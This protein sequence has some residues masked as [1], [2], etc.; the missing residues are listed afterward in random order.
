MSQ[1]Y[2]DSGAGVFNLDGEYIVDSKTSTEITL[3]AAGVE[4]PNWANFD[5]V[6]AIILDTD[7]GVSLN[8]NIAN[9]SEQIVVGP[10]TVPGEN[11][12]EV[13][14]DVVAPKGLAGGSNLDK[15]LSV[16]V[17]FTFEEIDDLG[18]PTGPSFTYD[19]TV[20]DDTTDARFYT[21]KVDSSDGIVTGNRYRVSAQRF[22]DSNSKRDADQIK[23]QRLASVKFI[24]RVDQPRTTRV[25]IL[26]QA[27]EQVASIQERKFNCRA[28]RKVL[29]W[30]GSQVVGDINSGVGL[31]ASRRFADVFLHYALDPDLGARQ[32]SNIDVETLYS[33][34]NQ[35]DSVFNGE[36]GEFSFTFDNQNTPA[37]EEMRQIVDA[38]RCFMT[39]TGSYLSFVRD[40]SQ[41]I[42][43]GLFNRRNKRPDSE[44]K[45]I[46]FNRPVDNDGVVF[47]FFNRETN[48]SQTISL[49]QDLPV[50]DPN[51]GLPAPVNPKK[52]ESAGIKN[53]SQAWD[54][55]QYEFNR[56]IHSRVSVETTVSADAAT[57]P[58]NA[59]VSHVDGTKIVSASSDGEIKAYSG[60]EVET[61]EPCIFE[62]GKSY[63][64][65][66]RDEDGQPSSALPVTQRG[67]SKNGFVLV[68]A[69]PLSLYIRGENDYQRGMLYNF[70]ED[71][72]EAGELYLL[73]RKEPEG[74]FYY[75]L[76]LIN[77]TEKYYQADN[78]TPPEL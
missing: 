44:N 8:P 12:S 34:Q 58:L 28:V 20:T 26:T 73:Q 57:L 25:K 9:V 51:Y 23:W 45:S 55:A 38:A 21:F 31:S 27:T 65:I 15:N 56:V 19:R 14:L 62:P 16:T 18:A 36:K 53:Y 6:T 46:R 75:K 68:S 50:G 41:P 2:A 3:S 48:Q 74:D 59:R 30:D 39:R 37:L 35:L 54:R 24:D 77:Y 40:Q 7:S 72:T 78:Q 66:L 71:G 22:S 29:T 42:S 10:F 5:G 4:N 13:W 49:P 63:S 33:I 60:L 43:R 17:R 69:P 61:S 32:L 76:E 67:D 52:V 64:V 11:Y 1:V 70:G 47:E